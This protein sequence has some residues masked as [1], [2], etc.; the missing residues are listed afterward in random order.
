MMIHRKKAMIQLGMV[1]GLKRP[2]ESAATIMM[3]R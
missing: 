1:H 3:G 2:N